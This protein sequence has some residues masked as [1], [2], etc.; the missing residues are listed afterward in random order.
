MSIKYNCVGVSK[1]SLRYR[2]VTKWINVVINQYGF[3]TGDL[4]FIFCDDLY[5]IEINKQYLNHDYFTD[6]VTFDYCDGNNI[7][8]DMFISIDRIKENSNIFN[9]S[10]NEEFLRVMVHGIL[11]LLGF[12]D[13]D[14]SEKRDMKIIEDNCLLLFKS[15]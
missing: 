12:K 7:S 13:H 3:C 9:S 2:M 5:L 6:I 11:H 1:P 4:S 8:G 10:L 14:D 15:L